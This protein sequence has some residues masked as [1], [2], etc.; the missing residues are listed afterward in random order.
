MITSLAPAKINLF[1][2]VTGKRADG[3]HFLE[4]LVVFADY[5]DDI[6]VEQADGLR[7][8]ISGPFARDIDAGPDNLVLKAARLLQQ[9]CGARPGARIHL[10]KRLPVA[11]GIGGGSSD[12]ATTLK[13]LNRLWRLDITDERL[14]K[15]GLSL[16]A[17][18]PVCLLEKP[19]LM[20]G[21]GEE[22]QEVKI[23]DISSILLVNCKKQVST[24]EVFRRLTLQNTGEANIIPP[25]GAVELAALLEGTRNDLQGPAIAIVPQIADVISVVEH[26][27]GCQLAR[28]SGSGATVFGLF[29]EAEAAEAA[30]RRIGRQ[31]PDWWVSAARIMTGA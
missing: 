19:A 6:S 12:A 4:S 30:A 1:L 28:M 27:D 31:H 2:H 8:E 13:L 5:G 9:E 10:I 23:S 15:L 18:V 11:S 16:G 20:R 3:Y 14:A 7:L 29:A 22:L 25:V 17:D 24:A 21:I 26:L